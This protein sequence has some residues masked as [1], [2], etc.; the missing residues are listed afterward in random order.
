MTKKAFPDHLI[1]NQPKCRLQLIQEFYEKHHQNRDI[2]DAKDCAKKV[3]FFNE[4]FAD[5]H[6]PKE[7]LGVDLGCRGGALTKQLTDNID[8]VGVDI[9]RVAIDLANH[10]GIPC[11]QMDISTAIDFCNHSFHAVLLSE[12]LEHLPHPDI[13]V[14]EVHRILKPRGVFLGSVPID[15][16]LH[17]RWS[18]MRGGRLTGDPTHLHHF[19][20]SELNNLLSHFFEHVVYKPLRG[21]AARHPGW[22]LSYK[23]FVRDI[24]WIAWDPLISPDEMEIKVTS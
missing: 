21:T 3:K 17:R 23:H 6:L 14:S 10:T 22:G 15:Y 18:V 11:K 20:F 5:Y 7:A 24:A 1:L 16:H 9:D 2:H 13:T 4:F 12:V 8:W 19:S